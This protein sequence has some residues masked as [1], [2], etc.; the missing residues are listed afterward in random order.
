MLGAF[1]LIRIHGTDCEQVDNVVAAARSTGKK[2]MLGVFNIA[3]LDGEIQA[4]INGV[5]NDWGVVDTVSIGNEVLFKGEASVGELVN[6]INAGRTKLR[7][8]GYKGPVVSVDETQQ[9]L[10]NPEVCQAS[11]YAAIN[12][13]AYFATHVNA[14]EAGSYVRDRVEAVSRAC[15]GKR[16]VVTESGWPRAGDARATVQ[17]HQAAISSLKE[18]FSS[19][20]YLFSAFDAKWRLPNP[21][22]GFASA[23][24]GGVEP[25]FGLIF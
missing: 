19:D 14:P 17:N 10:D 24:N 21:A 9:V 8:A 11:D 25:W 1:S 15:G 12:C 3:D 7:A 23:D 18:A 6:A 20:M 16:V 22:L 5:G 4:I 2:V 13:H